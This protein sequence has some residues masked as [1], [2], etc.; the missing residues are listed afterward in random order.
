MSQFI[1]NLN[2]GDAQPAD[3]PFSAQDDLSLF[4]S[5]DFFDFD[6]GD[7]LNNLPGTDFSVSDANRKSRTA[8]W[9]PPSGAAGQDFLNCKSLMLHSVIDLYVSILYC[10]FFFHHH[11]RLSFLVALSAC[12]RHNLQHLSTLNTYHTPSLH[13]PICPASSNSSAPRPSSLSLAL[14][15]VIAACRHIYAYS[16]CAKCGVGP[17]VPCLFNPTFRSTPFCM[18]DS[19]S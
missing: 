5:T 9:Q 2:T 6:M 16:L 17:L 19:S 14:L 18:A 7:T 10:H 12:S 8:N 13:I 15:A 1:A 3:E 11:R 4:A